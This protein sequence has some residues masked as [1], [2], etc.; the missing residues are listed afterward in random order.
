MSTVNVGEGF[1]MVL[2]MYILLLLVSLYNISIES[3]LFALKSKLY[4]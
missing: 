4:N 1:V 3:I 2:Y